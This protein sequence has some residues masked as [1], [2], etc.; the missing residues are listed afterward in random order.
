[1][2][3]ALGKFRRKI[4]FLLLRVDALIFYLPSTSMV[5]YTSKNF[6]DY[7]YLLPAAAVSAIPSTNFRRCFSGLLV[8][9]ADTAVPRST[10]FF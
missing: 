10:K 1:M 3:S 4:F 9:P 7:F 6:Q 8:I 5:S 2:F